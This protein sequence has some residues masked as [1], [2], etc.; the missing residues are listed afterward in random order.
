[1]SIVWTDDLKTGDSIIDGE[2]KKLIKAAS[3]LVE[4][5]SKGRGRDEIG[6]AMDF[7]SSYTKEHFSHEEE[8]MKK[9]GYPQ[10]DIRN[11]Q[12]WHRAYVQQI[13]DLS[14]KLQSEGPT[15]SIMAELNAKIGVLISHIRTVDSKLAMFIQSK[16]A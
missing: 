3:D 10:E 12:D 13:V 16:N 1:M 4:S 8:L 7:L 14:K 9:H 15:I 6:K 11:H 2:H 5:C